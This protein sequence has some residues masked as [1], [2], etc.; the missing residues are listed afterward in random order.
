VQADVALM[1]EASTKLA[2]AMADISRL[3][4]VCADLE[5]NKVTT[6]Y[7]EGERSIR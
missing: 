6:R 5:A 2:N 1:S 3:D 7:S 4:A